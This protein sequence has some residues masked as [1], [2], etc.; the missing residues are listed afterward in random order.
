MKDNGTSP[1]TIVE[2]YSYTPYGERRIY[3]YDLDYGGGQ[4][5]GVDYDYAG[6]GLPIEQ[7]DSSVDNDI[8]YTGRRWDTESSL[9]HYRFR[10]YSPTLGRFLTRD[11]A[12]YIDGLN[13]YQY[14]RSNPLIYTDPWGLG[15]W[16]EPVTQDQMLYE[17]GGTQFWGTFGSTTSERSANLFRGA[18]DF[19]GLLV[20]GLMIGLPFV[21]N[22]ELAFSQ[23]FVDKSAYLYTVDPEAADRVY[24]DMELGLVTLGGWTAYRSGENMSYGIMD[25]DMDRFGDGALS[26]G[27]QLFTTSM[28]AKMDGGSTSNYVNVS[29]AFS[30]Q[31]WVRAEGSAMLYAQLQTVPSQAAI[32]ASYRTTP[33]VQT[34]NPVDETAATASSVNP[35]SNPAAYS[36]AFEAQLKASSYPGVSRARHFQEANEQLLVAVETDPGAAAFMQEVGVNIERT[37]TGLVPRTPPAGWTW[38]HETG[39]G[40]LR[41]VPRPQHTPGSAFWEVLHPGGR[42]GYSIWGK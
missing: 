22:D 41:L 13:L 18:R 5:I 8:G 32:A 29:Q 12:G 30:R 28:G 36:T 37:A 20:D 6:N 23:P 40:V 27:L 26:G 1:S 31:A 35:P 10:Q 39:A 42:G 34:V 25:G 14:V 11:P 21:D 16:A 3:H 19:G 4:G 38:H 17:M 33:I 15:T 24:S 7:A 2:T 9:W